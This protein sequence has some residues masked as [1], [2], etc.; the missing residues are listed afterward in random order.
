MIVDETFI[1]ASRM[2]YALS[3]EIDGFERF[4]WRWSL[5]GQRAA[6]PVGSAVNVAY[7]SK[8]ETLTPSTTGPLL[9]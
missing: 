2:R 1:Q 3:A 4:P 6:A 8:C 9:P 5:Q 7:G